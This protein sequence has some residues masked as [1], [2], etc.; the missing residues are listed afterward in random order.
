MASAVATN[1]S[2]AILAHGSGAI[3]AAVDGEDCRSD[4]PQLTRRMR[5]KK[6]E[7]LG[8]IVVEDK[9]EDLVSSVQLFS[10]VEKLK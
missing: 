8:A 4:T 9:E 6:E 3:A 5:M 2:P 7:R 10:D 1:V